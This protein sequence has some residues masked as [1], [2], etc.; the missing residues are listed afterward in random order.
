MHRT[1]KPVCKDEKNKEWEG[2]GYETQ[3][4][5][6]DSTLNTGL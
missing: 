2:D 5:S 3:Q 1:A 4:G 6:T